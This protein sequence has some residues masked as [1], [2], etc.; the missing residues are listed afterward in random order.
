[1]LTAASIGRCRDRN[2]SELHGIYQGS[3]PIEYCF[4]RRFPLISIPSAHEKDTT[5]PH[6]VHTAGTPQCRC[7]ARRLTKR[8]GSWRRHPLDSPSKRMALKLLLACSGSMPAAGTALSFFS[9]W[10]ICSGPR[11]QPHLHSCL[12][13]A[14]SAGRSIFFLL[15]LPHYVTT[16]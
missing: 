1:M 14:P 4:C 13:Y 2:V 3:S 16:F 6:I 8:G 7:Y 10:S 15:M 9:R 11:G 12:D 5:C